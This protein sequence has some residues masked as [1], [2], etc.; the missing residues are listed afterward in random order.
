MAA[1]LPLPAPTLL[2]SF[3]PLPTLPLGVPG[4]EPGV[5]R[6]AMTEIAGPRSSG[7]TSLLVALLR[8]VTQRGEY[9]TLL[10]AF[11]SFDPVRAE[12]SGVDLECLVWVRC[13]GQPG[14]A[15]K[16]ADLVI[17][18]GGF[19]MVALDLSDAAPRVLQQLPTSYWFRF[20]RAIENTSTA[21]V[22]LSGEYRNARGCAAR[23]LDCRQSGVVWQGEGQG[24]LL[25][26]L[27]AEAA[28]RKPLGRPGSFRALAV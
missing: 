7:K 16:A 15:L 19:G 27:Q 25:A 20:Q 21:L 24:R 13:Q 11:D 22:V 12:Q 26:G 2:R 14:I 23:S 6:G 10:D 28:S 9:A 18:A 3:Q 4:L 5:P 17:H 8:Q 1:L